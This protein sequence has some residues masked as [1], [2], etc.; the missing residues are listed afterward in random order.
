MKAYRV[1]WAGMP[2]VNVMIAATKPG[3]AR[4]TVLLM[5]QDVRRD[6]KITQISARRAP[7]Y[8]DLAAEKP[9]D[10]QRIFQV[11]AGAFETGGFWEP[12]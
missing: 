5:L 11:D 9:R 12:L 3:R 7:E 8:D 4:Y 6:A 1:I 10:G 2:D